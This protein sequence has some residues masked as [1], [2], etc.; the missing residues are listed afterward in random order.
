MLAKVNSESPSAKVLNFGCRI[1][2]KSMDISEESGYCAIMALMPERNLNDPAFG[3]F[4]NR[5]VRSV[6]SV[7]ESPD[8]PIFRIVLY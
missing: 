7:K 3:G 1:G 8:W 6:L 5:S 2:R 4:H